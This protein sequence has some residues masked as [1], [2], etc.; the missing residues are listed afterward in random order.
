MFAVL[1]KDVDG[2]RF[3]R[4]FREFKNAE[5]V[6]MDEVEDIIKHFGCK[7]RRSVD[8]LNVAKGIYERDETVVAENGESF[9]WAV[10]G[11][12]FQD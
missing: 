5:R 6:M 10:I 12:Y 1:I 7:G 2:R 3:D 8:E 9:T 11:G 4:Y